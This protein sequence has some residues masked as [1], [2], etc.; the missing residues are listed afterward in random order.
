MSRRSRDFL[1]A[2]GHLRAR[3][4]HREWPELDPERLEPDPPAVRVARELAQLDARLAAWALWQ[5]RLGVVPGAYDP[6]LD[7]Q[8]IAFAQ[9]DELLWDVE[10]QVWPA[11]GTAHERARQAVAWID[12]GDRWVEAALLRQT[13]CMRVARHTLPRLLAQRPALAV[14]WDA[15]GADLDDPAVRQLLDPSELFRTLRYERLRKA[16]RDHLP[17][18]VAWLRKHAPDRAWSCSVAWQDPIGRML[19]ERS[20][21]TDLPG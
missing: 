5:T 1:T 17:R 11:E 19:C 2:P 18:L 8:V 4:G 12:A 6:D 13:R 3:P 21:L 9:G 16:Y 15:S 14:A 7:R 20:D 10:R